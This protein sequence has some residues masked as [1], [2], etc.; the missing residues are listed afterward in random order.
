MQFLCA[1]AFMRI[2]VTKD[3]LKSSFPCEPLSL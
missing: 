1:G 2:R 3:E